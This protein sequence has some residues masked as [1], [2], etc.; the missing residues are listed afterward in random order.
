MASLD[1][2]RELGLSYDEVRGRVK[3]GLLH[4]FYPDVFAVGHRHVGTQGKLFAALLTCGPS[5]FLSHRT[6]AAIWGLRAINTRQIHVT[7]PGTSVPVR[8]NLSVH[9]TQD[10][11]G[12]GE[13]TTRTGLRV[14]TV[15]QLL[16][17]LAPSETLRELDRLITQAIRKRVLDLTAIEEALAKH[18]RR[19]G[20]GKL[21]QALRDYRPHHDHKSS[22][23]AA[24]NELITGTD[25]PPPRR[26]V[27]IDGWEL[28]CYWPEHKLAVE[29]DGRSYH[30]AI[31]DME[32]DRIK[33]AKLL[34]LG[35]RVLRITELRLT[36]DPR[37]VLRDV[38]A[39]LELG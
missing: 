21:K 30:T 11:L 1:Q 24:F 13:V 34:V 22:L 2:L 16:I 14:S 25:I 19:P 38:R 6:A 27:H 20:I 29:L 36:L 9:R 17:E 7:V 5:S 10:R 31:R 15:P 32:K 3:R 28:D 12:R 37:G 4:P 39:L 33:D 8:R 35:I 23:E 26:N 18:A